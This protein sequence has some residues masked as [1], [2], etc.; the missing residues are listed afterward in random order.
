MIRNPEKAALV[1]EISANQKDQSVQNIVK[2]LDIL[3]E[4]Y[5]AA[6]DDADTNMVLKN[7]GSIATLVYLR[8]LIVRGLPAQHRT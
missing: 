8:D 6:N 5:R 4:Q 7:Q 1:L 2:L 3:T